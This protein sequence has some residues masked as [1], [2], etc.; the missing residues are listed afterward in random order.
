MWFP[1]LDTIVE[2]RIKNCL[3][4]QSCVA[5][6]TRPPVLMSQLPEKCW[7]HLS[8]DFKGPLNDGTYI[9]VIMDDYSR[10]PVV[11]FTDTLKATS[12]IPIFD[13][14]LSDFGLPNEIRTDNGAPFNSQYFEN[15][16]T[17]MGIKHRKITPLHPQ[18][19]G[20]VEKFMSSIG[21]VLKTSRIGNKNW[22]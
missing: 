12:V 17:E 2:Q 11:E 20:E 4:C 14:V 9:L 22:K 5:D 1:R 7:S 19:N 3:E 8:A 18:A 6:H 21:K 15:Y 16:M 13:K 10:Y